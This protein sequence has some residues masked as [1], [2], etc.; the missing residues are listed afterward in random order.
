MQRVFARLGIAAAGAVAL[1]VV[2]ALATRVYYV[3]V[4]NPRVSSELRAEPAGARARR[5]MLLTFANG[6]TIPVNYLREG[7]VVYVGADGRWWR[8][9]QAPGEDVEMLIQGARLAGRARAVTTD[10]G[11]R[12]AVFARLRPTAPAWLPERMKGVL[13]EISL[14]GER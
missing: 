5:V 10:P 13:V 14:A 11:Y 4:V 12:D 3:H 1:V 7:R 8:R 2:L 9:L 6:E